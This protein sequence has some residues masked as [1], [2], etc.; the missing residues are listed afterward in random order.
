MSNQDLHRAADAFWVL[1]NDGVEEVKI[2]FPDMVEVV[3]QHKELSFLEFAQL[4]KRHYKST[5]E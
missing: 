4:V 5:T 2:Q 1:L 3:L